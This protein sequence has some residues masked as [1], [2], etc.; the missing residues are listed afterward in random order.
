MKSRVVVWTII[1]LVVVVGLVFVLSTPSRPRGP[2][3]TVERMQAQA[4]QV[5]AQAERLARR[6]SEA[7][8]SLTDTESLAKLDQIDVQLNQA[9][10]ALA[11]VRE[12]T[13]MKKAEAHL[14]NARQTMRSIRRETQTALRGRNRV[15]TL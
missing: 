12:A 5:E 11:G 3:M 15:P 1:G 8:R 4:A 10:Q 7:R 2:K 14:R 13:D 9:R 6:V